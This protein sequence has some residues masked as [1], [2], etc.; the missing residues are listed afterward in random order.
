MSLFCDNNL[1]DDLK[2]ILNHKTFHTSI[3]NTL[4]GTSITFPSLT[5]YMKRAK[6]EIYFYSF[7]TFFSHCNRQDEDGGLCKPVQTWF[8]Q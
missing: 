6:N 8:G 4:F 5:E 7:L 2:M 1:R 3:G